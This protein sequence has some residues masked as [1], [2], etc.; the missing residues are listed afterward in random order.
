V[1][2]SIRAPF[3]QLTSLA[4]DPVTG[5]LG[6]INGVTESVQGAAATTTNYDYDDAARGAPSSS[7][8]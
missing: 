1:P 6:R 2:L 3:N 5:Y 4:L 7:F 8:R